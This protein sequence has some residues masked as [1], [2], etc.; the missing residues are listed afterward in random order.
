MRLCQVV[1]VLAYCRPETPF[2]KPYPPNPHVRECSTL[3]ANA[4]M[5]RF[6]ESSEADQPPGMPIV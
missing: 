1:E 2:T 6:R 4:I 5:I 3:W